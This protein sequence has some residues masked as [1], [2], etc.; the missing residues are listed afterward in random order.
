MASPGIPPCVMRQVKGVSSGEPVVTTNTTRCVTGLTL[1]LLVTIAITGTSSPRR[2]LASSFALTEP[3]SSETAGSAA[4]SGLLNVAN[5]VN[6]MI[7]AAKKRGAI[8]LIS[9]ETGAH[10]I[11][12]SGTGS[13]QESWNVQLSASAVTSNALQEVHE[14]GV[15]IHCLIVFSSVVSRYCVCERDAARAKTTGTADIGGV[16]DAFK[17]V[18]EPD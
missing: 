5:Y 1:K 7:A 13:S 3:S 6:P 16:R 18:R 15:K 9:D 8:S 17:R 12:T 10:L 14:A 2:T 11:T 4:G